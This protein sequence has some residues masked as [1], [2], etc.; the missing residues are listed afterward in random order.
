VL[1]AAL[2]VASDP[3]NRPGMERA[4]LFVTP[5]QQSE[6]SLGLQSIIASANQQNIR[7]FVW[8]VAAPDVLA[9][10]ETD[11]LRNMAE[12]TRASF[13]AFSGSEPVPD[14]ETLLEPLR[15]I[16]QLRYDSLA[17]TPGPQ[18]VSA[19][20]VVGSETFATPPLSFEVSLQ[21]PALVLVPLPQEITRSFSGTPAPGVS[22]AE[23][24]LVPIQQ[25]VEFLVTFPDGYERALARTSL[26]VDG[27]LYA[28]NTSPPFDQF[29]WDL[30][31]YTGDGEHTL[32][33][34]VVDNLGLTGDSG[35]APVRI[36]VPTAT[37]NMVVA[38]SQKR[39]LLV[40]VVVLISASV[41]VLVLILAGRIHPRPHPG[42]VRST[43]GSSE[44]TRPSGYRERMRQQKDPVTQPVR[45]TAIPATRTKPKPSSWRERLPWLK[46]EE[47]PIPAIAHLLPLVHSN[48]PTLPAPMQINADDVTLGRD[49]L[50]AALVIPDPSIEGLHARIHYNGG[51]FVI[52]DVGSVAGTWVNFTQ[53][54]PAGT[55]LEHADIIHL[56]AVGF[57][58]NLAHPG[59]GR[60]TVI[61]PLEPDNDSS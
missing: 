50:Q 22:N 13:F 48:E 23:T 45:I 46:P 7:I 8:L 24:D 18:Q 2:Q 4:V 29:V 56:G 30:R 42:Q 49:P 3:T 44:K 57:R 26:Y 21:P 9:L 17:S 43:A 25:L 36:T 19:Q 54:P 58:F 15:Y 39:F 12:Q 5:P 34:E 61:I 40:G 47:E 14:L 41:L 51:V 10:P 32:R 35:E 1:S 20:V 59:P 31:T 38:F 11:L 16:Y 60:K 6:I 28:E 52:T 27:A 53:V 55:T 37:Q 33:V